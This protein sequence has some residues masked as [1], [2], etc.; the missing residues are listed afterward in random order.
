MPLPIFSGKIMGR[1]ESKWGIENEW[2][3]RVWN[4][5]K[6]GTMP[7][8]LNPRVDPFQKIP[9]NQGPAPNN[10]QDPRTE[11][12]NPNPNPNKKWPYNWNHHQDPSFT[13]Q[14]NN[15]KKEVSQNHPFCPRKEVSKGSKWEESSQVAR[16]TAISL[17]T[18]N[19]TKISRLSRKIP[20]TVNLALIR[21]LK[22]ST[23][24][25]EENY[26]L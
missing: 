23:I 16:S 25:D 1:K 6:L 21:G 3:L 14:K 11:T 26:C 9:Q 13:P 19:G 2:N 17:E 8:P 10:S 15:Q 4:I 12:Q 20:R 18:E 7:E 22:Y 24:K 5:W